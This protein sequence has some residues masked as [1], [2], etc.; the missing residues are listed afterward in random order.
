MKV[1]IMWTA[2]AVM[3]IAALLLVSCNGGNGNGLP[4]D[5]DPYGGDLVY[6]RIAWQMK[7]FDPLVWDNN[8]MN[9]I[10]FDRWLTAPWE[11]G[12]EG[13]AAM[14]LKQPYYPKG[15]YRGE[16]LQS[17]SQ[18][19][20]YQATFQL[21]TGITYWDME[22]VN[23]REMTVDDIIW[24]SLYQTFHPRAGSYQRATPAGSLTFW[25]D[26]M[27][28]IGGNAT[29]DAR[30]TAHLDELRVETP[31]L[32]AYWPWPDGGEGVED[33]LQGHMET[34][35]WESYDVVEAE[36]YNTTGL[37]LLT[38]YY[39]KVDDYNLYSKH[40]RGL[41]SLWGG[42]AGGVWPTPKEVTEVDEFTNWETAVGTGP[43]I[44]QDFFPGSHGTFI[45]NPNYW[46][47]DPV[48]SRSGNQ[49]PYADSLEFRMIEDELAYY[50]AL[51]AGQLDG[52][53]LEY[54]QVEHF[55]DSY[56]TGKGDQ[57]AGHTPA[58]MTSSSLMFLRN[59]KAPFNDVRVRKACMLAIDHVEFLDYYEGLGVLLSWPNQEFLTETYTPM[60]SLP[61]EIQDM[62]GAEDLT[63]AGALLDDAGWPGPD[64][65]TVELVVYPSGQ[66]QDVS[67][68]VQNYL[69]AVG[70]T[71]NL[72]TVDG[73]TYGSQLYQSTY[74]DMISCWWGNDSPGDVLYWAEGGVKTSPYNFG[75]VVDQTAYELALQLA[76]IL[77][78]STRN[79][80]IKADDVRRLGEMYQLCLPT[81]RGETFW[82][83]W[84]QGY[85][86]ESDLG[87][88][89]ESGWGE[90]PKYI[91][92]DET[93][94]TTMGGGS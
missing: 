55:I 89:D 56:V 1:K 76:L 72:I 65:F 6:R 8:N 74:Q 3:V 37:A 2:V 92:I 46:Q 86:G 11:L 43:W 21:K 53:Y 94:K 13:T 34:Y 17:F 70:I 64:R 49:L 28:E 59:D 81:A 22:P 38:S 87:Y 60:G 23:G 39:H 35:Y 41:Q 9:S 45:R 50:S 25:E 42:L 58:T 71:I 47:N 57:A 15:E 19:D 32:E 54:N 24:N 52:G 68:I 5:T 40:C 66:S 80:L 18:V 82:W 31:L 12:P 91:W 4:P 75:K 79:A 61:T 63:A 14:E 85:S 33:T 44:L 29:M 93:L 67:A 62:F 20:L 84:I 7:G 48:P 51:E 10:I 90:I 83:P 77:D 30:L 69:A 26:Y 27:A 73:A 36:G 78:E 88:P 16:Y